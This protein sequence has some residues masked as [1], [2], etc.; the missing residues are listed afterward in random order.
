[1]GLEA[2][3]LY[4][5]AGGLALVFL[6]LIAW[7]FIRGKDDGAII[8][9]D[10][11]KGNYEAA[12]TR[13][14]TIGKLEQA[15]ELFI[16]AKR[17]LRAAEVALRRQKPRQA[18]ELFEQAGDHKRAA[19]AYREAGFE[20]QAAR[21]EAKQAANE[22]QP[23]MGLHEPAAKDED[24]VTRFRNAK[25]ALKAN[26]EAG[27]AKVKALG[28]KAAK[29]LLAKGDLRQA[30]EVLEAAG[31]LD[32]AVNLYVNLLGDPAC[33]ANLL[34]QHGEHRRA[35][36]LYEIAG[37]EQRALDAWV[38]WSTAAEDPFQHVSSVLRLGAQ[39]AKSYCDTVLAA[40][41]LMEQTVDIHRAGAD[42]LEKI[43]EARGAMEVAR[44]VLSIRSADPQLKAQVARLE[45]KVAAQPVGTEA[46]LEFSPESKGE[47][48][49]RPELEAM[50]Q[51]FV[52]DAAKDAVRTELQH[53]RRQAPVRGL[54]PVAITLQYVVD[55]RVAKA[56]TGP[57]GRGRV[58]LR[59]D[60]EDRTGLRGR[61][62]P[63]R[64]GAEV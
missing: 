45:G 20:G 47:K 7:W 3:Q 4:G 46:S 10:I 61:R 24:E 14:L 52:R 35:A 13:A 39:H 29:T 48:V 18:A 27:A 23:A 63:G 22:S 12:A 26:D 8:Q 50:L 25:A 11:K 56:R 30:A 42:L 55:E 62:R 33:A 49:E 1:M 43:G 19:E 9:R 15:Y 51:D 60:R 32:A 41:P 28:E 34:A 16:L 5:V 37:K 2:I 17:P 58:N 6:I 59:K 40:R 53:Q 54:E 44:A 64:R 36:E 38:Q 31:L 21:L 57:M